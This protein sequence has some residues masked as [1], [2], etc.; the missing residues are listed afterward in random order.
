MDSWLGASYLVTLT[1]TSIIGYIKLI[2]R[3]KNKQIENKDNLNNI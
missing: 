1:A 3:G 2:E